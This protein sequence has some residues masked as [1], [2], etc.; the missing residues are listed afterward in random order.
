M[1]V[2]VVR[3]AYIKKDK[4]IAPSKLEFQPRTENLAN[5]L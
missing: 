4:D 5:N 3:L 1:Y 2:I